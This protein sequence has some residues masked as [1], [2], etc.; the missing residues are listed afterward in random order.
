MMLSE[1]VFNYYGVQC[2]A[3]SLYKD[4]ATSADS[5]S[6]EFAPFGIATIDPDVILKDLMLIEKIRSNGSPAVTEAFNQL[7]SVMALTQNN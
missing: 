1:L 3:V 2:T 7:L 5:L 4:R 6:V